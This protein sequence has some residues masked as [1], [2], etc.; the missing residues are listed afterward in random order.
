MKHTKHRYANKKRVYHKCRLNYNYTLLSDFTKSFTRQIN[1]T[2]GMRAKNEN[3]K[4]LVLFV[5]LY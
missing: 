4:L 1:A 5:K 2:F 3:E